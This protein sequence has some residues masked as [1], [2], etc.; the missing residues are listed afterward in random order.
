M[1]RTLRGNKGAGFD[2]SGKR[3]GKNFWGDPKTIKDTTHRRERRYNDAVAVAELQEHQEAQMAP[4]EP[5]EDDDDWEEWYN[6]WFWE[7]PDEP[8]GIAADCGP[9]DRPISDVLVASGLGPGWN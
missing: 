9:D 8:T 3:M 6:N 7:D 4:P 1:A 2:Y 5:P